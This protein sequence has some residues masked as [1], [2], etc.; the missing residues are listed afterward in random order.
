MYGRCSRA[1]RSE[2][3]NIRVVNR[4][5][6]RV[7]QSSLWP[8]SGRFNATDR[9]IRRLAKQRRLSGVPFANYEAVLEQEI[10]FLV[11]QAV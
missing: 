6:R 1:E 4:R 3:N 8:I 9:A 11:N 2:A 5:L 10:S 7:D